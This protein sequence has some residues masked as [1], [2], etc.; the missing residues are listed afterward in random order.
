MT[1]GEARALH[2]ALVAVGVASGRIEDA[3]ARQRETLAARL[4]LEAAAPPRLALDSED[5]GTAY[6]ARRHRIADRIEA[7]T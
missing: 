1:G 4:R 7:A 6:V 2:S 5:G 3:T